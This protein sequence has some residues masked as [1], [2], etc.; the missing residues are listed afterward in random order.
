MILLVFIVNYLSEGGDDYWL[1]K[2]KEV[3]ESLCSI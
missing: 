2:I 1:L 3:F